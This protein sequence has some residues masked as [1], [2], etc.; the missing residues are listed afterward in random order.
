MMHEAFLKLRSE[1]SKKNASSLLRESPPKSKSILIIP[2]PFSQ[3]KTCEQCKNPIGSANR[4]DSS[5]LHTCKYCGKSSIV[6][7]RHANS[8]CFLAVYPPGLHGKARAG[9]RRNARDVTRLKR[10]MQRGEGRALPDCPENLELGWRSILTRKLGLAPTRQ[11]NRVDN[12]SSI[13][14]LDAGL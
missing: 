7:C 2:P 13:N 4:H 6:I 3:D 14:V 8:F 12:H 1:I 11:N 10:W 5:H 9:K